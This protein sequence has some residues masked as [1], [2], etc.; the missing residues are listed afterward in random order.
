MTLDKEQMETFQQVQ[1]YLPYRSSATSFRN[2]SAVSLF[3]FLLGSNSLEL[4]GI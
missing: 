3:A 4:K 2:P 1:I